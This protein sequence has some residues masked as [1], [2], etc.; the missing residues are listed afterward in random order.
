[1]GD[2]STHFSSSEFACKDGTRGTI[3]PALIDMLE[4]VRTRFDRPLTIVSGYRTAAW[5]KK[6]GGATRSFH[7]KGMAA[8]FKIPGVPPAEI[9]SFCD[10][11]W[12]ISGVGLYRSWVHLDCRAYKARWGLAPRAALKSEALIAF[13]QGRA[14]SLSGLVT[15]T[16]W[17]I[18][19]ALAE[20]AVRWAWK[21][22]RD[23]RVSPEELLDLA[24]ELLDYARTWQ[25]EAGHPKPSASE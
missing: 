4:V 5:N 7:T 12:P 19:R 15:S 21:A 13:G 18:A 9:Y 10:T 24:D 20:I 8:D 16:K 1:M 3:D 11:R 6:V 2:L 17:V 25:R 23:W 14:V 22:L